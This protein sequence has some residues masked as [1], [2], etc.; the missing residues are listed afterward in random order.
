M[1]TAQGLK[2]IADFHRPYPEKYQNHGARPN[3]SWHAYDLFTQKDQL[4]A[5]VIYAAPA[6]SGHKTI[7]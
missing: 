5:A 6:F 3:E 7:R 4:P 1:T 2:G